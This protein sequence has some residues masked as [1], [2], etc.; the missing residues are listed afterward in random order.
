M[1]AKSCFLFMIAAALVFLT[2]C[3]SRENFFDLSNDL[4]NYDMSIQFP[5]GGSTV[6]FGQIPVFSTEERTITVENSGNVELIITGV[7]VSGPSHDRFTLDLSSMSSVVQIGGNTKFR[8]IFKI[9]VAIE[10]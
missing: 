1:K 4:L 10:I 9:E 7:S 8:I 6:S 5:G 2:S 3:M